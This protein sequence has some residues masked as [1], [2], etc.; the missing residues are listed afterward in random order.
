MKNSIGCDIGQ[1]IE[2]FLLQ[3]VLSSYSLLEHRLN[4]FT[5]YVGLCEALYHLLRVLKT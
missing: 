3:F 4:H 1:P 2:V 5:H